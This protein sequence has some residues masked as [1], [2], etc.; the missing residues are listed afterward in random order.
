MNSSML[1]LSNLMSQLMVS[2]IIS[3]LNRRD[4]GDRRVN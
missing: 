1:F 4:A 3:I 2:G